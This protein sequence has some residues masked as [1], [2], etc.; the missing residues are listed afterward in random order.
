MK[1]FSLVLL[2]VISIVYISDVEKALAESKGDL[3]STVEQAV[4]LRNT[5]DTAIALQ[6][7]SDDVTYYLVDQVPPELKGVKE[8]KEYY[9]FI[10]TA[11]PDMKYEIKDMSVDGNKVT[12]HL[13]F[14]G[15]NTG[16][17]GDLPPTNKK[18]TFTTI[19]I[20][21]ITDGEISNVW[22]HTNKAAIYR[23][24]GM[25]ELPTFDSK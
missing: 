2:L 24:L 11:Y 23:Q 5:G 3:E 1:R 22:V 15:T 21:E 25:T 8:I 7:Y 18:V 9:D 13:V 20:Y 17:R 6:L 12:A 16:P 14:N 10:R 4:M 19:S